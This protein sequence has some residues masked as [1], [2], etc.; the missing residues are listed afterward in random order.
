[1]TR[2]NQQSDAPIGAPVSYQCAGMPEPLHGYVTGYPRISHG[3]FVKFP[4]RDSMSGFMDI[5]WLRLGH[6]TAWYYQDHN[7]KWKTKETE[8]SKDD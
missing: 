2:I 1:M 3:L 8:E 5:T 7:G 6:L 4:G